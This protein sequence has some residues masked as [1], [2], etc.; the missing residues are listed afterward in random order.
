MKEESLIRL[1][2]V[3]QEAGELSEFA[4][5]NKVVDNSFAQKAIESE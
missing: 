4:P 5:F 1:Q 2:K 3:M